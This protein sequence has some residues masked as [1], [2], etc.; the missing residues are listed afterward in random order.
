ME[1]QFETIAPEQAGIPSEAII[2][3]VKELEANKVNIH[4][5]MMLHKGNIVAEGYWKPFHQNFLHRMYSVGKSFTALAIGL[6]QEE[7]KLHITDKICDYFPEK[8]PK[9]GAHPWILEMTIH[10][11]L[12]MTTAHQMTTYKRYNSND[13]VESF[14]R[15]EPSHLPGTIFSYDT[16]S[17]HV[18]SALVEKLSGLS[19]LDYLRNKFLDTIG[20]SKEAY[21]IQ[22]PMGVSQG[23]SGLVCTM[24]D[25]AKVAY[26]CSNGGRYQD[27]QLIPA[28]FLAEATRKQ[29]DTSLQPFIDEQQGYGYQIWRSRNDGFCFYGMGGQLALCFPQYDFVYVTTADTQGHPAA[30]QNIYEAFYKL[31]LPH[32]IK[33]YEEAETETVVDVT[34]KIKYVETLEEDS[35]NLAS[36]LQNLAIKPVEGELTNTIVQDINQRQYTFNENP[37]HIKNLTFTFSENEGCFEYENERGIQKIRF[38]IG[39]FRYQNFPETEYN[40]MCSGAW[41][42]DDTFLLQVNIIDECFAYLKVSICFKEKYV[43]LCMKR[44]AEEFLKEYDGFAT[45]E[46]TEEQ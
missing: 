10:D 4:S 33:K 28:D 30:L 39:E 37:M 32:V 46:I 38:G 3:Y 45:G 17:T 15:V 7:G 26:V 27:R 21:M 5:F 18:L 44:I 40:C 12:C 25:V 36:F 35:N 8:L 9:E 1:L 13:W 2:Q 41:V 23:G 16:S 42:K 6:L 14:F 19:L 31:V 20:F 24:R 11:M 34:K 22:D 29:V 43:T